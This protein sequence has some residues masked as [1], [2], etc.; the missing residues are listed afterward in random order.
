LTPG[1]ENY[2]Y[3]LPETKLKLV[4]LNNRTIIG[5]SKNNFLTFKNPGTMTPNKKFTDK[6]QVHLN[7]VR[8]LLQDMQKASD[9]FCNKAQANC[10]TMI[11]T[12]NESKK[13]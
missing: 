13:L 12:I 1:H 4:N 7:N 8:Q 11:E 9:R 10:K 6:E 3:S 2:F 5:L